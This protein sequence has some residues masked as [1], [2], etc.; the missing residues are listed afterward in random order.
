MPR[1]IAVTEYG[2][3]EVLQFQTV[4]TPVPAAD[5]VLIRVH[6]IGLNRAESMWRSGSYVEPVKLPARLGYESAG[7]VL[8]V[9]AN[10]KHVVPG[11][12]VS[13][14]PSFSLNDYGMYGEQVLAPAHAV[15]K[16]PDTVSFQ[17]ATAIWNV[18]IT[19]YGALIE[20]GLLKAGDVVLVPAA[21]SS[22][23]LGTLQIIRAAGAIP[24]ALTRTR[25]KREQLLAAG[26][27]EVIVTDEED[28]VE[29][30]NRITEGRGADIVFE[31][32]GGAAF[33]KLLEALRVGGTIFIYGA[34]SE[35]PTPLPLLTVIAKTP[36]IRG[37]NLF[38]TTTDPERLRKATEYVFDGLRSGALSTT[39]AK[40]FAFDD[41]VQAH[42]E[43]EKNLHLG[44]IVVN[45]D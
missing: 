19:P 23:G 31:P 25:A 16:L 3:P 4:E 18:F 8:A 13:T 35:E 21:S 41:M 39:I 5:E 29:A 42:R 26:A 37:Y 10:V 27:S 24:V 30:V 44:R 2:G 36:V 17:Q 33:P 43:L 28:L 20:N 7:V 32:V 34:L 6:A 22:V 1:V 11:D 12:R 40:T 45:V 38:A 14:V 9:G 15:V